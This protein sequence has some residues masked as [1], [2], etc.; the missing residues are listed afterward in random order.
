M[1]RLLGTSDWVHIDGL[2]LVVIVVLSVHVDLIKMILAYI[3]YT[4]PFSLA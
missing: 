3:R 2:Q 1:F 4:C